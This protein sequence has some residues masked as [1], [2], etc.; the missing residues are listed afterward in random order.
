MKCNRMPR[1]N[2][3]CFME[4]LE[5]LSKKICTALTRGPAE[6]KCLLTEVIISI[7]NQEAQL[8]V[9]TEGPSC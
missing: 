8:G 7:R 3:A 6:R 1:H 9:S 4:L 2:K 5:G